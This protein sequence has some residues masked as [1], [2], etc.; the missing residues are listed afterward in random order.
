MGQRH[1]SSDISMSSLP[2]DF[3]VTHEH[4]RFAEFCDACRRYRYIGLCYGS[5]GVGKSLSAQHY[6]N[7]FHLQAYASSTMTSAADLAT[8]AGSTTVFYTPDVVNSPRRIA[9]DIAI[10]RHQLRMLAVEAWLQEQ[11]VQYQVRKQ[12]EARLPPKRMASPKRQ[13]GNV[14]QIYEAATLP[15]AEIA[16]TYAQQR[17]TMPD[18][19]DLIII[20][21][22]DRLKTASLE[23]VR[24]I[25]DQSELGLVLIGMPGL[26]KRLSRYPQL[27]SLSRFLSGMMRL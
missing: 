13:N 14:V 2:A 10:Q 8:V 19:T 18:P 16:K 3:V 7:W 11:R 27:L 12:D 20:D 15:G 22:A 1:D 25:F 24:D 17:A 26:E 21:E 23:Q 6:V 5:P 4:Q 9:Q